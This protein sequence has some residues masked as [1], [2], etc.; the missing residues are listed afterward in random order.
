MLAQSPKPPALPVCHSHVGELEEGIKV[1]AP[2]EDV[3][4]A[5]L[6]WAHG[7]STGVQ[8]E[9][10][11][12]VRKDLEPTQSSQTS[13]RSRMGAQELQSEWQELGAAGAP[14]P[15]LSSWCK[16]CRLLQGQGGPRGV[17]GL[18][19]GQGGPR[20]PRSGAAVRP[21]EPLKSARCRGSAAGSWKRLCA[22]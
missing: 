14:E 21:G 10:G 5:R 16:P 7:R 11:S 13:P 1:D 2:V 3:H 17:A 18:L 9:R 20:G 12:G 22:R 19:Q 15:S 4:G 6:G 8:A